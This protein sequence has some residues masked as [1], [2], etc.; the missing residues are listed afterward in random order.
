MVSP[1][2]NRLDSEL[3]DPR[4]TG[5][6]LPWTTYRVGR[7]SEYATIMLQ[8]KDVW[9]QTDGSSLSSPRPGNPHPLRLQRNHSFSRLMRKGVPRNF[10]G[11]FFCC[12]LTLIQGDSSNHGLGWV[13]LNFEC[14]T[15]C[16]ILL[17]LLGIWQKQLGKTMNIQI[18]VNWTR[19]RGQIWW[20]TLYSG[21]RLVLIPSLH[22]F[23]CLQTDKE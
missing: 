14:S 18:K 4:R 23:Y 3:F 11:L 16:P 2:W 1:W 20:D 19:V 8:K 13:Y 12:S 9:S 15:V 10:P 5:L 7:L 17:G 21:R 22:Q 6:A